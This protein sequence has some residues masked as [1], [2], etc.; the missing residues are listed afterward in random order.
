MK[1]EFL[2]LQNGNDVRGIALEGIEGEK[3]NFT[4][5]HAKLIGLSFASWLKEKTGKTLLNIALGN[6]S[7][8]SGYSLKKSIIDGI[9]LNSSSISILDCGLASTP[10]MFM[11]TVIDGIK[12][13]GAI[14][15]TASH[16][17]YNRNGLKFFT[18]DGALEKEDVKKIL[19]LA[20]EY[21]DSEYAAKE[22]VGCDTF[23]SK[24][25]LMYSYSGILVERIRKATGE[26]KPLLNTKIVVDAGNGSG[27][28]F[29]EKVLVPLGADVTGS[30]FLDPDGSFPNHIPNPEDK[31]AMLSIKKCVLDNS[32]DLGIIFDTDVDRA[33]VVDSKGEIINRNRLIALISH[34]V[35]EENPGTTIVTDSVT[36]DELS[37]YIE[38]IG[39]IHHRFK[40]GYKNVINE[41]KRLNNAGQKSD[42]AIET[43]GHAALR[44]NYFLDDGA[45]LI[46]KILIKMAKLRKEGKSLHSLIDSLAEPLS[47]REVRIKILENNFVEYGTKV[48]DAFKEFVSNTSGWSVAPINYEGVRVNCSNSDEAGW[49]LIRMSLHDPVLPINIES[50]LET[51]TDKIFEK[52]QEF[53]KQFDKLKF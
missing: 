13:D 5:H 52:I 33:A 17:P 7:R 25:N 18:K 28:F 27:G 41:S 50:K 14:M 19:T 26:E 37:A 24:T 49:C 34:I 3:V 29:V 46:V 2:S 30:Q 1:G 35:L 51:G 32:A 44:E 45:Y 16:L 22:V 40:R 31:E 15:I 39:G 38:S 11:S 4:S 9:C 8:L 43:S 6:D 20:E 23:I 48:L 12:A 42:L 53:L 21:A 47:S 36:S 10:A